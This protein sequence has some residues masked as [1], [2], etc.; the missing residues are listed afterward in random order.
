[1]KRLI[2]AAATALAAQPS[3]AAEDP[4]QRH[5]A[6][7]TRIAG[8]DLRQPL[9]L[10]EANGGGVV[11]RTLETQGGNWVTPTKAFDNLF[12]V[13]NGFVGVWVLKTS[14]GLILFDSGQSEAEARDHIV[15][16]LAELGLDPR[17]IRYVLVTHGHFDH[18]GGAAWFQQTYG[19]RIGLSKADWDLIENPPANAQGVGAAARPRRDLELID[20]QVITLGDTSVTLRV[21]PGHTP[22]TVSAIVPAREG[23]RTYPLSLLGSTAFPPNV[24]PSAINGGLRRYDESVLRFARL[25]AAAKTQGIIN[26][27]GFADGTL[28]RLAAARARKPGQPNPFLTGPA[29]TARY[30]ALLHQCLLAAQARAA[31]PAS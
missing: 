23:G 13:G 19:A 16:G 28:D 3:L 12:F 2:L 7:A 15:P 17:T 10:C 22:G 29:F 20:G 31:V 14:E 21:T 24:E 4:V 8:K 18:F 11:R 26:T 6:E 1:M 5:V 9:F 30:Y 25:S 27:H